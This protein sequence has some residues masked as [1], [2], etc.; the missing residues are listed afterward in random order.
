MGVHRHPV[1]LVPSLIRHCV[2]LYL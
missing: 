2:V 1:N